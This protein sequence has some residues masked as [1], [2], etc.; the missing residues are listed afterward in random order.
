MSQYHIILRHSCYT[1]FMAVAN[2]PYLKLK[3]PG[4]NGVITVS[5]SFK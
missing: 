1:M 4:L 5:G 2:Y 3:M